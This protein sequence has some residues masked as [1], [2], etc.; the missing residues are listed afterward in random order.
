MSGFIL[1]MASLELT[2]INIVSDRYGTGP[3]VWGIVLSSSTVT[4]TDCDFERTQNSNGAFAW[5]RSNSLLQW[6]RVN[7]FRGNGTQLDYCFLISYSQLAPVSGAPCQLNFSNFS[8]RQQSWNLAELSVGAM[9]S[10]AVGQSGVTGSRYYISSN[11]I[12]SAHG[13][14]L[15]GNQP[16]SIGGGGQYY[17]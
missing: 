5:V 9:H 7:N 8:V 11:S 14:T 15:P 4:L 2:G 10:T 6:N 13:K 3:G 1:S 17:P 12:M 16:G